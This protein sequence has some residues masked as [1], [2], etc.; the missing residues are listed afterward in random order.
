M[1]VAII[2]AAGVIT[3]I[4]ALFF[5]SKSKPPAQLDPTPSGVPSPTTEPAYRIGR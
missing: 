4:L 3:V 5:A 1:V 2:V